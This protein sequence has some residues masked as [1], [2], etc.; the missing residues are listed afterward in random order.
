MRPPSP[1]IAQR[2]ISGC[3]RSVTAKLVE[4]GVNA[5]SSVEREKAHEAATETALGPVGRFS[6]EHQVGA[7]DNSEFILGM[8]LLKQNAGTSNG[9]I[10]NL[11]SLSLLHLARD[12]SCS[13]AESPEFALEFY[14]PAKPTT[15]PK[16]NSRGTCLSTSAWVESNV[17]VARG[18]RGQAGNR[19]EAILIFS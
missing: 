19:I 11:F 13:H 2:H 5:I 15:R 14:S 17:H 10:Y 8:A 7:F 9:A 12:P 3:L 16:L 1:T 6:N 18:V 4:S